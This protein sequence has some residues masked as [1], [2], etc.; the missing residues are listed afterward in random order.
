MDFYCYTVLYLFL[1]IVSLRHIVKLFNFVFQKMIK[2]K[3]IEENITSK[4]KVRELL[5]GV[6]EFVTECQ[7]K[8]FILRL[9]N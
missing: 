5:G 1:Y 4:T 8:F 6:I 2:H 7:F 3:I 9:S